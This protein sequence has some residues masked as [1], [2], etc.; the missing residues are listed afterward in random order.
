MGNSGGQKLGWGSST[1]DGIT[2]I[3]TD[4]PHGCPTCTLGNDPSSKP[5]TGPL[6]G[7]DGPKPLDVRQGGLG[8][9]WFLSALMSI[10]GKRPD[11]I[12][13]MIKPNPDGTYTVTFQNPDHIVVDAQGNK[14]TVPGSTISTVVTPT[15]PMN[16]NGTPK[17]AQ[18][19]GPIWP[20]ILEKGY[21]QTYGGSKGWQGIEGGFGTEAIPRVTGYDTSRSFFFPSFDDLKKQSDNG[22]IIT[23]DT[24]PTIFGYLGPSDKNLVA[25]HAYSV[26]NV[27]TD[28]NGQQMV[29]LINPWNDTTSPE[30]S[31]FTLPY[32]DFKSNYS[33]VNVGT[34]P[35]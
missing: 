27:Y 5:L 19:G 2:N 1:W 13:K 28:G 33:D 10:A 3:L 18:D 31:T 22:A 4:R 21:A 7:P 12:K 35:K 24:S 17:Y 11:I 23:A 6:F 20:E 29:D 30:K 25:G 9:C 34:P 14:Y 26:Q 32:K 16:A 8:D 15:V